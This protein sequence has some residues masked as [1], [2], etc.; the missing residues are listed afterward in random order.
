MAITQAMC[1]SFKLELF[2]STHIFA[3]AA[4]NTFKMALYDSTATLSATTTAYATTQEVVGTGYTA[5]G[6]SLTIPAGGVTTASQTAFV[7]FS[8]T[9]W[10]AA[11]FTARGSEL[12]DSTA[13]NKAV[14][15]FDFGADKTVSAGT[16]T[17]QFPTPD[18][19]NATLR[20]R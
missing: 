6:N 7:D 3:T 19:D 15:V 4:G 8:D 16:F 17:I 11:S 14:G 18:Q 10:A 1:T 5:G 13:A 20:I 12:Y 9:S 2:S